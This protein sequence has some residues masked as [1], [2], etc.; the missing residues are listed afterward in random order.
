M[1]EKALPDSLLE[2]LRETEEK[3]LS[4]TEKAIALQKF[5]RFQ[6]WKKG[7]PFAGTL[8][9]TPL[10]NLSCRMCYVHL[11]QRQMG[12]RELLTSG[13]WKYLIDE[14]VKAGMLRATLT[15]G[16]C[17]TFPEFDE[18]YLHLLE[19]GVQTTI[20]T[21]GILLTEERIRFFQRYPPALIQITLYGASEDDYE[22]VTGARNFKTVVANIYQA[23]DGGLP[24]TIAITPNRFL[25]DH[26]NALIR[27]VS[28]LGIPYSI[29]PCLF[30]PRAET[31]REKDAIDLT[32]DDYIHL[33]TLR[34]QL[35]NV[36]LER[37]N[38]DV[39]PEPVM[40]TDKSRFGLL[41]GAG[42]NAF[43]ITWE[44]TMLPC[45]SLRSIQAFPLKDGFTASW[46]RVHEAALYYPM[47]AEC[48]ECQYHGV[49]PIC[50]A[51]HGQD[52]PPGHASPRQCE[53]A[54]KMAEAGFFNPG[55]S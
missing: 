11:T 13:Q 48:G 52:A 31:G 51:V 6:T 1:T 45:F 37:S 54:L 36:R 39:L 3:G 49:C 46:R 5:L 26:G 15:G 16:E 33:Y 9:L 14:A 27:F 40:H 44:G 8:E 4:E 12:E 50:P 25:P 20:L 17:L 43:G 7:I 18:I 22:Q 29:N 21:N 42:M 55:N 34:A 47:P 19:R 28:A 38:P 30:E 53:R 2:F 35:N 24:I 23:K 10:C 41:C 32:I